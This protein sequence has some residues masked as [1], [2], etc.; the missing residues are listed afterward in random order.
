MFWPWRTTWPKWRVCVAA[1]EGFCDALPAGAKQR[2]ATVSACGP[3]T[4]ITAS[5]PS[6][7]GVAIAAMVSSSMSGFNTLTTSKPGQ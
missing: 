6:P 7:S 1:A 5:P 2:S 4:R 3:E